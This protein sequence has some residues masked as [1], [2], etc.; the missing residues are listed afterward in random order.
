MKKGLK[1]KDKET[2]EL[3]NKQTK[4]KSK[5]NPRNERKKKK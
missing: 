1:R 5:N 3:K 2:G 4:E